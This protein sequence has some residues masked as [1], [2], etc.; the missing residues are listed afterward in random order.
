V[1]VV[2]VTVVAMADIKRT[3][4]APIFIIG[5]TGRCGSTLLQRMISSS[6]EA[7]L[8]GE[9]PE[10]IRAINEH[11]SRLSRISIERSAVTAREQYEEFGYK[12]WIARLT[13]RID[14]ELL[15][16]MITLHF[17]SSPDKVWGFKIINWTPQQVYEFS[18]LFP[19]ATFIFVQRN[20]KDAIKSAKK[21]GWSR[22]D[23]D[24]WQEK[25][26]SFNDFLTH[27]MDDVHHISL[28]YDGFKDDLK[29]LVSFLEKELLISN[30]D[31]HFLKD[32]IGNTRDAQYLYRG[33]M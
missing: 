27:G 25:M 30:I 8:H 16:N 11:Y 12:G 2:V 20:L 17:Q 18:L 7:F 23:L 31:Y 26:N 19:E 15:R 4:G 6:D 21:F 10:T 32:K 9:V 24:K 14:Q 29:K 13:P 28:Y 5:L 33:E 1:V 3:E 22:S